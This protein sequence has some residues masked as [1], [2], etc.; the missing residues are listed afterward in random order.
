MK[1]IICLGILMVTFLSC[2]KDS[3]VLENKNKEQKI[4]LKSNVIDVE[5]SKKSDQLVYVSSNP[6]AINVFNSTSEV[7][8]SI[9]LAYIPTCISLSQ[10]GEAAVVGHD[11]HVTYVDLKSKSIINTYSVSCA[12]LDIVLGNNKWAY[13]FAKE[14]QWTYIKSIN[15]NL[16]YD[17]EAPRSIYNQ[18][19]A[20]TK[21]RLHPSGK[22]IYAQHP[23]S[24]AT[25]EKFKIQNG[26]IDDSYQSRYDEDD[27][28]LHPSVWFS[29]DGIRIFSNTKT[30]LKTS[31]IQ[32]L[33]MVYNGKI[34]PEKGLYIEWL[35][36]SSIKNNLFLIF[37]SG[38]F[39]SQVKSPYIYT[40]NASNLS[41]K[42]K[43][44]LEKYFVS[45]NK[46]GGIYYEAEPYFVFS[47][48]TGNNLFVIT[49]AFDSGLANEWAIQKIAIE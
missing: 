11:G 49:K 28:A 15:M 42:N 43:L 1:K 14:G 39:W 34:N 29:E 19:S 47:N 40:Y 36:H 32:S 27:Y 7:I 10:D 22:Y 33:D 21:G 31:E 2:D 35:D 48:S 8:E 37:S 20:G 45:D 25:I 23:T 3:D 9:P 17:N 44:E 26:N 4:I 12:A 13:V 30:V 18:I 24:R 5:Y 38:D 6:S 46:G 16:S 41:F